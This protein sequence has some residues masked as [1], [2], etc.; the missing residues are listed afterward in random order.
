MTTA[1][2]LLLSIGALI[3]FDLF[4]TYKT[5]KITEGEIESIREHINQYSHDALTNHNILRSRQFE[6]HHSLIVRIKKIEQR[7]DA[8]KKSHNLQ[9][10]KPKKSVKKVVVEHKTGNGSTS[11]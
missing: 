7:L 9:K 11:K 10:K 6:E 8:L 3:L 5:F 2:I 4:L 1:A